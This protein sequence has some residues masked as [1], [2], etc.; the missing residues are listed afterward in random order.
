[1]PSYTFSST[2]NAFLLHGAKL[3][4]CDIRTDTL[5]M[6]ETLIPSLITEKTKA[7]VSVHYAGVSCEMDTISS[8]AKEN[9]LFVIED[10]AQ[11]VGSTFN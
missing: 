9:N 2:A 7:I 3:V 6:D 8:I 10:D 1:M 4:F 11:A 5:N